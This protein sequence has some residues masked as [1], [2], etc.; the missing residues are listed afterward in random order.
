MNGNGRGARF[1]LGQVVATSGIVAKWGDDP[2]LRS[3]ARIRLADILGQTG[4]NLMK[5][6]RPR[7]GMGWSIVGCLCQCIPIQPNTEKDMDNNRSGLGGNYNP[8]A[9]GVLDGIYFDGTGRG[10][11]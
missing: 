5:R 8:A 9:R 7:T 6:I 10:V 4:V 3:S 11:P 2:E 1:S